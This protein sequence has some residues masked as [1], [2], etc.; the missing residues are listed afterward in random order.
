MIWGPSSEVTEVSSFWYSW[1]QG[2][3]LGLIT[4]S[5]WDALKSSMTCCTAGPSG[6][7]MPCQNCSVT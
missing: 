7:V 3:M 2:M 1:S 6:P 5:A 4:M